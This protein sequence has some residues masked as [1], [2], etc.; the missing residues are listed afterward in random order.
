[1][2]RKEKIQVRKALNELNKIYKAVGSILE[3][4]GEDMGYTS[5]MLDP[6]DR[7]CGAA[8]EALQALPG[9]KS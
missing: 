8:T 6:I 5:D 2:T 9:M 4:A 3:E 1:M 7:A